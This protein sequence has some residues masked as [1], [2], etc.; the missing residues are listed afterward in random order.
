MVDTQA[1]DTRSIVKELHRAYRDGDA[2]RVAALIDDDIDWHIHGPSRVFPFV[3]HGPSRVF[4][5]EG[6][7]RGKAQVMDV[8]AEIG[9]HFELQRH[10]HE[11]L[12]AEGDRAAV[13]S[14]VSFKQ[15]ATGR[16]LS[17]RLINFIRVRD[18][19]IVEFH[20]FSDTFDAVEQAAG[21]WLQVPMIPA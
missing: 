4:P 16:T 12:I 1:S 9:R 15:A 19:R 17:M 21:E 14:R 13:L 11:I 6:P 18:G 10:D 20:E 8:L 7:R 3:I 5:F 2:A